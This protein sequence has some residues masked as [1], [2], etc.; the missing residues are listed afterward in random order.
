MLKLFKEIH[1]VGFINWLWFVILHRRNEFHP[2]LSLYHFDG[3]FG[4]E[5][6]MMRRQRAHYIN[7]RLSQI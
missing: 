1:A 2:R 3:H 5:D 6:V 4:S 7:I